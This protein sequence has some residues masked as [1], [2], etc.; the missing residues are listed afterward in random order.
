[1]RFLV[2]EQ[3]DKIKQIYRK[4]FEKEKFIVDFANTEQEVLSKMQEYDHVILEKPINLSQ[5]VK[6]E[7]HFLSSHTNNKEPQ[8]STQTYELIEKPFAMVTILG[9]ILLKNSIVIKV[10]N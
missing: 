8:I 9:K 6:A 5:K 10:K 7:I 2:L 1:M 4:L 3:N